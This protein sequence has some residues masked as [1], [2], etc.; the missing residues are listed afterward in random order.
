MSK[1]RERI[2]ARI[3][4]KVRRAKAQAILDHPNATDEMKATAREAIAQAD[5]ADSLTPSDDNV[6]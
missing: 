6:S 5:W 1:V 4:P 3:N 2:I